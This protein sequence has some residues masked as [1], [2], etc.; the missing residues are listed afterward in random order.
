M[1]SLT[2]PAFGVAA[3]I[4]PCAKA[5]TDQSLSTRLTAAGPAFDAA[6]LSFLGK[7]PLGT[8]FTTPTAKH[9]AGQVSVG[10]MTAIYD[11]VFARKKSS[12]R[13]LFYDVIKMAPAGRT[14]PYCAHR[15]VGSLDHY[16]AKSKHP[17]LALTPANLVPACKDCNLAKS[18]KNPASADK[19]WLHP[20]FENVDTDVWLK[21]TVEKGQPPAVLFY[22]DPPASWPA[23]TTARVLNQF[24]ELQLAELYTSQAGALIGN[25]ALYLNK[26]LQR[27]G[28]Q[29]VQAYLAEMALSYSQAR[30]NSWEIAALT[31]MSASSY[32]CAHVH[33]V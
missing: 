11:G 29:G 1:R 6:E 22:V 2:K 21:A 32:F 14:C 8:L 31:A 7:A 17:A 26:L 5:I 20:Y 30:T 13:K 19:Q 4:P 25:Y 10:E 9:V 12:V 18:S 28:P 27:A 3:V 15:T 16:L 23:V 24:K 33:I